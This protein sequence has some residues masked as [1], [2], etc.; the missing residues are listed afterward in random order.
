[1]KF[2]IKHKI[3]SIISGVLICTILML[4][5]S[6]CKGTEDICELTSQAISYISDGVSSLIN[7]S[8]TTMSSAY[9]DTKSTSP[10]SPS[11]PS[12][13]QKQT[14]SSITGG[15]Q[16]IAD[17]LTQNNVKLNTVQKLADAPNT[18]TYIHQR[19][20]YNYLSDTVSRE[21]YN[22]L[23]QSSYKVAAS[24]NTQGYY[25]IERVSIP[26]YR[27]SEA[28]LRVIITAFLNDNPQ[29]F[30]L[31]NSYSYSYGFS[32][33]QVQLYSVAPQS[34]INTMSQE[35]NNKINAIIKAMPS[36][37]NEF[38][39]ELYLYDYLIKNCVYDDEA[40]SNQNI[41]QAFSA[42]GAL[43]NG[44]AVCEGYS[45]AM[46]LLSS[47]SGLHCMLLTGNSKGTGHMWNVMKINGNWYHLDI[48]WGDNES[49]IYNYFN[50]ND[51]AI[52]QNRT[53]LPTAAS[54]TD[55]QINGSGGGNSDQYNL[56]VP[57]CTSTEQNYYKVKGIR[58]GDLS[59]K[60]D[61]KVVNALTAVLK[62]KKPSVSFYIDEGADFDGIVAGMTTK[63]P[64]KVSTYFTMANRQ[65]GVTNKIDLS[66]IRY[67]DDKINRGITFFL[68]YK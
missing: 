50:I 5:L 34:Q 53:I 54:L 23:L 57:A 32:G 26:G 42:Y 61:S 11:H 62:A 48:T 1:M 56:A 6:G 29:I 18:Y 8:E 20:G 47:Y 9:E 35:M 64:Y 39:R 44:K 65:P 46:Q 60:N 59:S 13:V 58:I 51:T 52:L 28:Q 24:P 68:S 19:E 38:D 55:A 49:A 63:S 14:P 10:Q 40:V 4:S 41:W 45:R 12:K 31:A 2:K 7:S 66:Q 15:L 37:M 21:L 30:W 43:I 16:K 22:K 3:N 27:I 33:T 17:D 67:L 25:P 36:G